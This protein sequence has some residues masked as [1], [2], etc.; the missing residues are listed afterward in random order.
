MKKLNFL[1]VLILLF[2]TGNLM[3]QDMKP[4]API[5]SPLIDKMIGTWVSDPYD[6][7]GAKYVDEVTHSWILNGQFMKVDVKSTGSNGFTYEGMGIIAPNSDGTVT[8]WFY[9]IFGKD[10]I[11][12]YTGNPSGDNSVALVGSN[13]HMKETRNISVDGNVMIQLLTMSMT[14]SGAPEEKVTITYNKK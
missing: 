12:T 9:D 5:S 8:G 3:A 1:L 14:G 4:P 6:F 10:N 7:M 2:A 11:S 13:P